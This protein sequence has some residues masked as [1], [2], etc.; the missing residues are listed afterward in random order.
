MLGSNQRPL[1]CEGR[2]LGSQLFADVQKLLQIDESCAERTRANLPVSACTGVL[3][4]YSQRPQQRSFGPLKHSR[5]RIIVQEHC[6]SC[7]RG[8]SSRRPR[9]GTYLEGL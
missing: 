5:P 9:R 1:P 6:T 2:A 3:L 4:V 7:K 8:L